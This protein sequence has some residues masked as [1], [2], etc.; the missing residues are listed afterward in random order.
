MSCVDPLL[1]LADARERI[2]QT[3][4]LTDGSE[5]VDLAQANGRVLAAP[6]H[7]AHDVP[8]FACS[9]MDGY[10]LRH[11]DAHPGVRLA[12]MDAVHAGS[13]YAG[14]LHPGTCVRI[15]TGATIPADADTVVMQEQVSLEQG[16]IVIQE[17]VQAGEHIRPQ[18]DDVRQG[19]QMMPVGHRLIPENIGAIA[20]TGLDRV[21]VKPNPRVAILATGDELCAPGQVPGPGHIHES[22]RHLL[23][24]LLDELS[25]TAT[26]KGIIPD[27][28]NILRQTLLEAAAESDVILTTGGASVGDADWVVQTVR[29]LG[30][31]YFWQVAIKPGK[32][33][34]FG[35]IGKSWL[36]GMPGNPVAVAVTFRQLVYPGLMALMGCAVTKP[37]RFNA[38][39]LTTLKKRPGRLEFRRAHISVDDNGFPVV[40]AL[41][42]QGSHQLSSY[43]QSNG[44]I[45]L[46][47]NSTGMVEGGYVTVEPFP[48]F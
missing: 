27:D 12:V 43:C 9:A 24:A 3:I 1:T 29:E 25:L 42:K 5:T 40:A 15:L 17:P 45:V 4:A 35:R 16:E 11:A 6:V 47:P 38:R 31:V 33:F 41:T 46:E 8:P 10:A 39:T 34:L 18:G 7:A 36:F 2:T 21:E 28:P 19:D 48:N 30:E 14:R 32:P 44:F 20:A 23:M 22:N 13:V 26:D 37:L